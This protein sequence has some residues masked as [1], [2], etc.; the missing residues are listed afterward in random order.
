MKIHTL[1]AAAFVF[2]L[3]AAAGEPKTAYFADGFHGGVHG[4]Y[5]PGYTGFLVEQLKAHPDW[6]IN[7]EIEPETWDSVRVSEPAAYAAFKAIMADQSDAGRIEIVNPAYAQSYMFQISGESVIRQFD[8]GIR[9]LRE[10]FPNARFTTYSSEEPCFTSCLPPVLKSFGFQFAVLKN[11]NTGWGGYT[12]AHGGELVNWIGPDGT[13]LLTVPRYASEALQPG[14]CWQ[15]IAWKNSPDYLKACFDQAIEHPVG[16]CL[17]DAGWRG[18]PWIGSGKKTLPVPSKYITWR[19]YI[20]NVTPAKTDDDWHFT[21][22]DVKPGLMWGAQVLQRIAQQSRAAEHRLLVAE[23]LAAMAFVDAGRPAMTTAIDEAWHQILLTQ[24][25]DCWIVP[26]NGSLGNT[27]A[28]QVRLWTTL[29]NAVS[30][31]SVSRSVGALLESGQGRGR[32]VRLFN[33]T[34]AALE[35]VVPA[36]IPETREPSKFVSLNADGGHHPTQVVKSGTPGR[37]ALL[38]H[39]NVPPMGYATV[40]LR[41]DANSSD[42]AVT[43]TSTGNAVVMESELYRIEFDPAKGG[44]IRSLVA[45][46]LGNREFVDTANECRFNELRG[47]FYEQ[48]GFHSSA[49]QPAKITVVENGPLRAT[50]EMSGTI[51]DNPFVQRVSITQGSPTIDCSVRID[52]QGQPRIGESADKD[53]YKNRQRPAYDDRFKLLALFP[54]RLDDQKVAK[55]APFDV[56]ESKLTDT[57]YKSWEDIKNNVIL[58]WVDVSDGAGAHGLALFSDHTT[59]Y[60]HGPDFPLGLTLQY[61]GKGLWGR[62]Y[63][64]AGPTEI[65]YALMPHAGRWDAAG[66]PAVATSW[67]EPVIGEFARGAESARR[68]LIDPGKSGW[69]IPAMFARD[70]ALLVRLFNASGDDTPRQLGIGFDAAKIDLVELDGRVIEKLN[71]TVAANGDRSVR[72]Q[73]PR[74]GI[75]T[76]RFSE[77]K[78]LA[79]SP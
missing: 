25:H 58:N 47:H 20:R 17:Q 30:D 36:P 6:K 22:E 37:S 9:K 71:P 75:R 12:A 50:V 43:A 28:D 70:G 52:W 45:K 27:W 69:E 40:E 59:S 51:A 29:A 77:I 79:R 3:S 48:G 54:A 73:I 15:T 10:H 1:L 55:N 34:A 24:H 41:D 18:G 4:H 2:S 16:M 31:L 32:F 23:K 57:F 13:S 8:Y 61:A 78:P 19:D 49:D 56:C 72:L 65:H 46:S 42:S 5:P 39:A 60:T 44:T 21:Q 74:F 67:Q 68:S 38:V 64:V 66:V 33:P 62:D 76:L 26:Y 7:L 53:G 63:R 35:A 14:S 11:P